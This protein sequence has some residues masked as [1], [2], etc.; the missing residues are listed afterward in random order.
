MGHLGEQ[1]IILGGREAVNR[2]AEHGFDMHWMLRAAVCGARRH[3]LELRRE[4]GRGYIAGCPQT[5]G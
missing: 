1:N 5:F 4:P 3:R 2:I